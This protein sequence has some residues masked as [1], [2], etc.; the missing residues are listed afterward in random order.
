[1]YTFVNKN[2]LIPIIIINLN[3]YDAIN[4]LYY[5]TINRNN[6]YNE[7]VYVV[8]EMNEEITIFYSDGECIYYKN[9]LSDE[10]VIKY[11]YKKIKLLNNQY[12]FKIKTD[13]DNNKI[14]NK[15]DINSMNLSI[16]NKFTD[17]IILSEDLIKDNNNEIINSI[18]KDKNDGDNLKKKNLIKLIEEVNEMY[19][20]EIS[21]SKKLEKKIKIFD[22]KIN[23][24]NKKKREIIVN[25][26]IKTQ[27]EYQTWKKIKYII[28]SEN[29]IIKPIHELELS[30]L[31][32]P[33][34][35][36]SK[37]EYLNNIIQNEEIQ[38]LIKGLLE[39]N[40]D[41]R[42]TLQNCKENF[43]NFLELKYIKVYKFSEK[44]ETNFL[45]FE[46]FENEKVEKIIPN[47]ILKFLK[48]ILKNFLHFNEFEIINILKLFYDIQNKKKMF[49]DE[50]GNFDLACLSLALD[51]WDYNISVDEI[52]NLSLFFYKS[53][54][55]KKILTLK[56]DIC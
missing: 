39:K 56:I 18:D 37:Y 20:K 44:N 55:V 42:Y 51:L 6:E 16:C 28:K 50:N 17:N 14:N 11:K 47:N 13:L 45:N 21:N 22:N 12:I 3:E 32:C 2:L 1:M 24:L 53:V 29:N 49:K 8:S 27:S 5:E 33:V 40:V 38:S 36:L 9:I 19:N 43:N 54:T 23:K 34:F 30:Y 48:N 4:K 10:I 46:N 31:Q 25:D 52:R 7:L 41:L 26:I 15:S 35:F